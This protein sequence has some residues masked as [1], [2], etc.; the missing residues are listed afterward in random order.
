MHIE[1][2]RV[3]VMLIAARTVQA[4]CVPLVS[5]SLIA[6]LFSTALGA[7]KCTE[8]RRQ[9]FNLISLPVRDT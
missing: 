9:S 1:L 6:R 3:C 2:P 8:A 5:F 4:Y 7:R